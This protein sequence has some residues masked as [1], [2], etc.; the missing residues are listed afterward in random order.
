MDKHRQFRFSKGGYSLYAKLDDRNGG[1]AV[2]YLVF[3]AVDELM[4]DLPSLGEA[5]AL[6]ERLAQ[7]PQEQ[8]LN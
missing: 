1:A 3:N 2:R 8:T 6:M 5:S 7:P 4:D